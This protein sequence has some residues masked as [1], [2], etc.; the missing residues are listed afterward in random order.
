LDTR[1]E[2]PY[3]ARK[4]LLRRQSDGRVVQ[5][6]IMRV[7]FRFLGDVVRREIESQSTPLGRI[8]IRHNVLREVELFKLWRVAPGEDLCRSFQCAV[9]EPTYGRTALIHCNRQPAIELLEIVTPEG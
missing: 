9:D 6:G 5:F 3:Y 4:I 8:L 2:D 1:I 7:D